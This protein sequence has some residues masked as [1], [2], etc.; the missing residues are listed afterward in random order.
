MFQFVSDL[1][2]QNTK[3]GRL[4]TDDSIPKGLAGAKIHVP[5]TGYRTRTDPEGRF[6]IPT[7]KSTQ[8]A[9]LIASV[10]GLKPDT[11]L[12][13][14]DTAGTQL[15][16]SGQGLQAAWVIREKNAS[17]F[18]G[19][20]I[21]TT[22]IL[23]EGELKKAACCTLSESF[24]TNNTVEV[25]NADG[26]SGIRQVEMLGLAGKYVLMTRDN[27]PLMRGFGVLT[28]LGQI[29]GPMVQGV[30]I[31]KG[32]GSVTNGHDGLTGGLNYALKASETDPRLFVNGYINNQLRA[33]GNLT[34]HQQLNRRT[35]NYSYLH[36]SRQLRTMDQGK[37]GYT[38]MPLYSRWYGGNH[39]SHYGRKAEVQTGFTLLTDHRM[40]GSIHN[41]HNGI[42]KPYQSFAFDMLEQKADAY[43][44]LGIFT[45]KEGSSSIGN[46]LTA[47]Q[48]KTDALLNS[49]TDRKW[50][51]TQ[52]SLAFSSVYASDAD[53]LWAVRT[54]VQA[55]LDRVTETYGQGSVHRQVNRTETVAGAF[56]ELVYRTEQFTWVAGLRAD[57]NNF[58]GFW[59]T[60]RTH[61]RYAINKHHTLHLQSGTGRRTSWL[62]AEFFPWLINN[63][64]V[65]LPPMG[66]VN[67]PYGLAQEKAWNTGG[68]YVWEGMVFGYPS[69]VSID[70]WYTRFGTQVVADRDLSDSA[71]YFLAQ[72]G[73][74]STAVQADWV[75][76]PYRR[77]EVKLSYRY[78][79][80]RQ[81]LGD[82]WQ[83]TP[84]QSVHR[85]L[86]VFSFHNRRQWYFDAIAQFNGPK[87]I[88]GTRTHLEN[89]GINR[90]S[91]W[92]TLLN[93]Q[94]RKQFKNG[95]E[96]Y[97]GG[98]NLLNVWQRNPVMSG[99]N[100]QSPLFDVAYAWGPVNGTNGFIGF[101]WYLK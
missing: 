65:V 8:T 53:H 69:T 100:P 16:I 4:V 25:S 91:P 63:R 51:G 50:S 101:R 27:M 39:L 55:M 13:H 95:W 33:E 31:A 93:V 6:E 52:K 1:G 85:M 74:N 90:Y 41:F 14:F 83:I 20:G 71:I 7:K 35:H 22:E 47:T 62:F 97:A 23:G 5:E 24:E 36:H 29:P 94:I 21:Q 61:L 15:F 26:V 68:N 67:T 81:W 66:L 45:N 46:I 49:L 99:L 82:Q 18:N 73:N 17:S 84:F 48:H 43:I 38:D 10:P 72:N 2:A 78:V 70:A 60:P 88:P 64:Q 76:R 89:A 57:A 30:H 42:H 34:S 86:A 44:K 19:R 58:Y 96:I 79:N 56:G 11:F 54:G 77:T 32:T 80:S 9:L 28:G 40:G 37:D 92:Y 12:F 98:E 75:F 3:P 59:L 87:R